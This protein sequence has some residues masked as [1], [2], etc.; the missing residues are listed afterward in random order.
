M[1]YKVTRWVEFEKL[2]IEDWKDMEKEYF[3]E[4]ERLKKQR[5]SLIVM[6]AVLV[7]GRLLLKFV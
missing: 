1:K 2:T 6:L 3:N 7:L 5:A 4:I